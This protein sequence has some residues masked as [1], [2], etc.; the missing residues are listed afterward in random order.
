M[1]LQVLIGGE[2]GAGLDLADLRA[3]VNYAGGYHEGHPVI[4]E[5]W[6]V[7][8]GWV[9]YPKRLTLEPSTPVCTARTKLTC[10]QYALVCSQGPLWKAAPAA[11]SH[12]R[13]VMAVI[14][15]TPVLQ[16]P[17]I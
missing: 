16:F 4:Q 1:T 14:A 9:G 7:R 11:C 13:C 15:C 5:L 10:H 17:I 3:H 8:A 2:G 6:R 12:C